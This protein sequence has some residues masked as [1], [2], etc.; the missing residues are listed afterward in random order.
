MG[1]IAKKKEEKRS[2]LLN[3]AFELFTVKG[4]HQTSISDISKKAGVAKGTFYL[5]FKDK[6][7][8]Q[9]LL[10][11]RKADGIFMNAYDAL[12]FEEI[13]DF[14]EQVLFIIHH[15]LVQLNENKTMVRFLSKHL[16][17]GIIKDALIAEG[18]RSDRTAYIKFEELLTA[19][20][21]TFERPDIMI[22][23]II[24][25]VSSV[26]YNAI[27]YQQPASIDQLMPYLDTTIE[28]I[29]KSHT[30]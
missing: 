5:Y 27:L 1:K 23:L 15:I 17:W 10:I 28:N 24:E 22:Y 2:A 16:S 8:L 7:S 13:Q 18:D 20:G 9:T 6:Y 19:S 21:F 3:A 12:A 25:L 4:L 14:V 11:S 26:S 29:I 30:R